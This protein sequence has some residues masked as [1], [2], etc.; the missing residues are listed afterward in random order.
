MPR[1]FFVLLLFISELCLSQS[2][3]IYPSRVILNLTSEPHNSIAITWRTL[4]EV[5]NPAVQYG[6]ELD[7]INLHKFTQTVPALS[8]KV[9]IDSSQ[10]VF[11]YSAVLKNLQSATRYVYRVG[12]DSVWG[13]WNTIKTGKDEAVPFEFVYLGDPQYG[14]RDYLP[15]LFRK[16]L[17]TA[18]DA[19]FWL[20]IGDLVNNPQKDALWNDFFQSL[21]FIPRIIPSVMVPG[22]HEYGSISKEQKHIRDLTKLWRPHFTLPENGPDGLSETAYTFDYQGVRFVMLNGNKRLTQQAAWM[23]SVL[24]SNPNRW[25]IAAVHQP[26]FSMGKERD[27]TSIRD[28]LMP[29]FDKYSVDLVLTGHDHVYSRSYKLKNGQIVSEGEK[30]TVYIVSVCGTKQYAINLIYKDLMVKYSENVALFQVISVDGDRLKYTAYTSS[31]NIYDAFE[32]V[33]Q[34]KK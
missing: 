21:E 15:R 4:N 30:G 29:L 27:H 33:K 5:T 26:V 8:E 32:L 7:S 11:H 2:K 12:G 17:M 24:A 22:N 25:T 18:P 14:F 6:I 31:G 3:G 1:Y 20:Y 9:Y 23:D 13:E 28:T 10:S 19:G 34:G 16:A